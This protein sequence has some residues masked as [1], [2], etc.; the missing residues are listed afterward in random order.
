MEILQV[1]LFPCLPPFKVTQGHRNRHGSI[2]CLWLPTSDSNHGPVSTVSEI[3]GD[4]SRK[5]QIFSTRCITHPLREFPLEFCNG[6]LVLKKTIISL[7]DGGKSLTISALVSI[8][9]QRVTDRQTDRRICHNNRAVPAR[10][11]VCWRAV[12]R[13]VSSCHL[14][15][16]VMDKYE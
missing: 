9:Y 14:H 16:A 7:P 8:Q 12:K 5:S 4:F 15:V 1:I 10:A 11:Q 2:G 3:N 13:F 6:G